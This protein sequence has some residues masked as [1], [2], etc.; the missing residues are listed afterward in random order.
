MSLLV[1]PLLNNDNWL[2]KYLKNIETELDY[3][4][5]THAL[6]DTNNSLLYI[7]L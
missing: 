1:G 2:I 7:I 6:T 3:K 5:E 4:Y